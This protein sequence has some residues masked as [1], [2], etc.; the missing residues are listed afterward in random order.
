M[1]GELGK[2][3]EPVGD[4]FDAQRARLKL[5]LERFR[6]R[7]GTLISLIPRDMPGYTVHDLGKQV[8]VNTIIEAA[9]K[10][11]AD[12][13]GLSALLVSTSKQMP[14]VV[15][16]LDYV[17]MVRNRFVRID[18]TTNQAFVTVMGENGVYEEVEVVLGLRND[19]FSEVIS[20]LEAGQRVFLLPRESFVPTGGPNGGDEDRADQRATAF[21]SSSLSVAGGGVRDRSEISW[22]SSGVM[23]TSTE[24]R[25]A[26]S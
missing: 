26:S 2:A 3:F 23:A 17:L 22:R 8:P 24:A 14:I 5:S 16:E 13:I 20:G 25:E 9:E 4:A 19:T 12:A 6:D 1:F 15:N 10:H 21:C 7:V 11:H 18:R